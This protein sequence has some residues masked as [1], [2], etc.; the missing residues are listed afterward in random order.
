MR[1]IKPPGG[2]PKELDSVF[3]NVY[4]EIQRLA[5]AINPAAGTEKSDK[6]GGKP[7]DIRLINDKTGGGYTIE[8]RFDEG[9]VRF[10]LGAGQLVN[11]NQKPLLV[12]Q[13][14]GGGGDLQTIQSMFPPITFLRETVQPGVVTSLPIVPIGA[15]NI[16]KEGDIITVVSLTGYV[17]TFTVAQDVLEDDDV[18]IVEPTTI[19]QQ[20]QVGSGVYLT[21]KSLS[22]WISQ[23]E[24]AISIGAQITP[25]DIVTRVNAG[26]EF[27]P[28]GTTI[29]PVSGSI[30]VAA[31]G[32]N[33]TV[34]RTNGSFV[35]DGVI[36]GAEIEIDEVVCVVTNTT[37]SV[38]TVTGELTA[39]TYPSYILGRTFIPVDPIP[40]GLRGDLGWKVIVTDLENNQEYLCELTTNSATG[41]E[42]L[43]IKPKILG[44]KDDSPLRLDQ[45]SLISYI[46]IS[47]DAIDLRSLFLAGVI[48]LGDL[49]QAYTGGLTTSLAIKTPFLRVPIKQNDLIFIVKN[50]DPEVV[51]PS[52][53]VTNP[54]AA[55]STTIDISSAAVTMPADSKV[56]LT[57][58]SSSAFLRITG[59]SITSAVQRFNLN[60]SICSL[61]SGVNGTN[62]TS[63]PITGLTID[64]VSGDQFFIYDAVTLQP[65]AITLSANVS[66]NADSLP[67]VSLPSLN[68]PSGSGI[69]L[70][71][72]YARSQIKQTADAVTTS[73]EKFSVAGSLGVTSVSYSGGISNIILAS[74]GLPYAMNAGERVYLVDKA[75]GNS[76]TLQLSANE[77]A[78]EVT[79]PV[80]TVPSTG[81]SVVAAVGSGVHVDTALTRS[82]VNQTASSISS[83]VQTSSTANSIANLSTTLDSA[84]VTSLPLSSGIPFALVNGQK[85]YVVNNSNGIAY[86]V[87]VNGDTPSGSL[88]IPVVSTT[89]RAPSGSGV[90]LNTGDYG[91]RVLQTVDQVAL[92]ASKVYGGFYLTTTGITYNETRTTLNLDGL[93]Y[94]IKNGNKLYVVDLANPKLVTEVTAAEDKAAT[95]SLVTLAIN[96]VFVK[97]QSG[98]SVYLGPSNSTGSIKVLSDQVSL[99]VTETQFRD[100]LNGQFISEV[101]STSTPNNTVI[102]KTPTKYKMFRGDKLRFSHNPGTNPPQELLSYPTVIKEIAGTAGNDID[103]EPVGTTQLILNNVTGISADMIVT[104]EVAGSYSTGSSLQVFADSIVTDTPILKS[105]FY[106]AGSSGWAIKG[107][108]SAEFND[109][110]IRGDVY[111]DIASGKQ[112]NQNSAIFWALDPTNV[113][114]SNTIGM[115]F[116]TFP[117]S[118]GVNGYVGGFWN[119]NTQY[120]GVVMNYFGSNHKF[121]KTT[122][123]DPSGLIPLFEIEDPTYAGSGNPILRSQNQSIPRVFSGSGAPSGSLTNSVVRDL[124]HR[125]D[126]NQLYLKTSGSTWT[127]IGPP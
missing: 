97:A 48:Y 88:S 79:I 38:L 126:T 124:Y 73:V 1:Q 6:T 117:L 47:A 23:L 68:V 15:D 16:L 87:T 30:V 65:T 43:P 20:L 98:S 122:D 25:R 39:G 76:Y 111:L 82:V 90:N 92:T 44:V 105:R 61:S 40:I 55:G 62:V 89:V 72:S 99:A 64:L 127:L 121:H 14:G 53:T 75:T 21:Q 12:T 60:N 67:I 74:P 24:Y 19:G 81:V 77:P 59:D 45:M 125:T 78:G 69:H 35:S 104:M 96:S 42:S 119:E 26:A 9:W 56:F 100:Y 91:T 116:T 54:K 34:T 103:G 46:N 7:G 36:N 109:V 28:K 107:D 123:S 110:T 63:L 113:T 13:G 10:N 94:P 106:S 3:R 66:S 32:S 93:L 22:T 41:A 108:G 57:S 2:I 50:G 5:Q 29:T 4:D 80:T 11:Q 71:N 120:G 70:R 83:I 86:Q 49:N 18:I 118:V 51:S 84:F 114:T 31:S 102:L 17:A 8:G 101:S 27:L 58:N 33:F 52:Y 85:L 95:T 115:Y 37:A 112:V